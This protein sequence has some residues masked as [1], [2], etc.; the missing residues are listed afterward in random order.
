MQKQYLYKFAVIEMFLLQTNLVSTLHY[1][2]KFTAKLI[3]QHLQILVHQD[4]VKMEFVSLHK[5]PLDLFADP[6]QVSATFIFAIRS[7]ITEKF[8]KLLR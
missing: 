3:L 4:L 2:W 8:S 1:T 5:T 6:H 7:A